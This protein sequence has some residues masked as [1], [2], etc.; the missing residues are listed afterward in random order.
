MK[1]LALL[2]SQIK[3]RLGYLESPQAVQ[4]AAGLHP[5]TAENY[6]RAKALR[7]VLLDIDALLAG[8]P[9]CTALSKVEG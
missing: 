2:Q 4:D 1:A 8:A 3:G 7:E 9:F 6:G 5:L